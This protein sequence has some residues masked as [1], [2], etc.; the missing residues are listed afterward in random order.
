MSHTPS[1]A[2]QLLDS[3]DPLPHTARLR[4]LATTARDL[5]RTGALDGVLADLA[6]RGR[7][8]RRLAALAALAGR[9]AAYLTERLTDPDPVVRRYALRAVRTLP[10]PDCAIA[11]AYETA[12]AVVRGQLTEA[13]LAGSRQALAEQL[14]AELRQR[15]GDG[16]AAA[17]LPACGTRFTARL[18]PELAPAVTDRRRIARFHPGPVLD[19]AW[20]ELEALPRALRGD[21]WERQ[22]PAV[23]AA[24]GAEPCR[25]LDLLEAYGPVRLPHVLAGRLGDL[26]VADAERVVRWLTAAER[27]TGW[28]EPLP[29]PSVLRRIVRADPAS[30]P[31]LGRHWA[32]RPHHLAALLKAMPPGRRA[33]FHDAATQ[34]GAARGTA[35]PAA[36]LAVLPRERRIAEA[37]R[38]LALKET[39]NPAEA[40]R[41]QLLAQLP[42]AEA[43]GELLAAV[44]DHE[45]LVRAAGWE[46]LVA[47]TGH[48]RDHAAVAEVVAM[49]ARRLRNDRDPV[50]QSALGALAALPGPLLAEAAVADPDVPGHLDRILRDALEA[51]DVSAG[52]QLGLDRLVFAVLDQPSR[53]PLLDWALSALRLLAAETGVVTLGPPGGTLSRRRERQVVQALRPWLDGA[54]EKG[55]YGPLLALTRLLG[56]RA[57]R[58]PEVRRLLAEAL[59]QCD[60]SDFPRLAR[61]W[62]ADRATRCERVESL[63]ADEPSAAALEPVRQVLSAHRTDLLDRILA[64]QPPYGRF[65]RERADRPL[66]DFSR[67]DRWLPRQQETAAKL[68]ADAVGDTSRPPRVRAAV[69]RRAARVPGHGHAL[70]RRYASSAETVLAEAALAASVLTDEP[71]VALGE[72]LAHADGDRA[73]VAVYAVGRAAAGTEPDRLAELLDGL[74]DP[75]KGTKVTSRK[76]AARLAAR[77][78]PPGRAGRMLSRI[79]RDPAAHPDLVAAAVALAPRLLS[80]GEV[81]ELLDTAVAA[82]NAA[83]R[84]A[85][86]RTRPLDVAPSHRPRYAGLVATLATCADRDTSGPAVTALPHWIAYAPGAAD[87]VRAMVCDLARRDR[88]WRGAAWVLGEIAASGVEHPVGGGAPGS[89][90]HRTVEQLLAAVRD[91]DGPEAEADGDLPGRQRLRW[92][93]TR[94][95]GD[96]P[97]LAAALARQLAGEPSLTTTRTNLLVRAVDPQASAPRQLAALRELV[98][99]HEDRPGL[100]TTTSAALRERHRSAEPAPDTAVT[101][102]LVTALAADGV[103]AAGLFAVALV[104]ALGSRHGWPEPCREQLRALR[105]HPGPDVRDAAL[106]TTTYV[107]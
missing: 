103:P 23:A 80:S 26:A 60:D 89:T 3:L 25:V 50:R 71:A 52:T 92:L 44:A 81:W 76:E 43:R 105:R 75:A 74:L 12:S 93:A 86:L 54:A 40:G 47:N 62:L 91:G 13:V 14:V 65:L 42:V 99:A 53:G 10:V 88:S 29:P 67:A 48:A 64:E 8:E 72:L 94:V 70:V 104:S 66:P 30:L 55:E 21:W 82:D 77:F 11:A 68:A 46:H 56:R 36:V 61:S 37:R 2:G 1:T 34:G 58:I 22:A 63:L 18:L 27:E 35:L 57:H 28:N 69:L 96:D 101:L 19:Q 4:L 100:A 106:G 87:T 9:H 97:G 38:G 31:A 41:L 59:G 85:V 16:E 98:A 33:A 39:G 24:V 73:R 15:W 107:E 45:A 6:G 5:A 17:L 95:V 90:L 7:Y 83:A 32:E 102:E 51:R 84:R 79:G 78:L 49:M 20:S